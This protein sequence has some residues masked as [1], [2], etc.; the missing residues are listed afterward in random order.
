[1]AGRGGGRAGLP[2]AGGGA[3]EAGEWS[4]DDW[5]ELEAE[6]PEDWNQAWAAKRREALKAGGFEVAF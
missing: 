2:G 6:A 1:M 5:A 4:V 3:G